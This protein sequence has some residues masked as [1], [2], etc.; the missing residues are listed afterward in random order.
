MGGDQQ[1][2]VPGVWAGHFLH[3]S[4][5]EDT[6]AQAAYLIDCGTCSNRCLAPKSCWMLFVLFCC[7]VQGMEPRASYTL[8]KVLRHWAAS[9]SLLNSL[10]SEV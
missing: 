3:P 4:V 2:L 7:L 9:Q 6:V 1:P 8:G 10:M 5:L